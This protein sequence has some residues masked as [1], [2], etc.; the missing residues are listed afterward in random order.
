MMKGFI[1]SRY[2]YRYKFKNYISLLV[3]SLVI[4]AA[5]FTGSKAAVR[6]GKDAGMP[7]YADLLF[8][9][10]KVHTIDIQIEDWAGFLHTASKEE[11]HS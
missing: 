9:D 5:V 10:S 2:Q 8:D 4:I 1:M 11:Y 3:V 7:G 6:A